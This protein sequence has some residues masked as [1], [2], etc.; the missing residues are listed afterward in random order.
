MLLLYRC[1]LSIYYLLIKFASLWNPKAKLWVNGRRHWEER[2]LN[3]VGK[4][5]SSV[6]FHFA[7]LGE[8]EQG[9]PVMEALKKAEPAT[10]IIISFFSPSGYEI[11]KNYP[12][13]KAVC[14]L[15]LDSPR[16]AQKFIELIKPT[17]AVFTKYEYWFYFFR[18]LHRQHIPLYIVSGIFRKNQVFFKWYG[19]FYRQMLGLITYFF[20][21]NEE[22]KSLLNSLGIT[23][24]EVSG[25]TRFDRVAE[26]AKNKKELKDIEAFCG[27]SKVMVAGSTWPTDEELLNTIIKSYTDWKFIIAPHEIAET[28]IQGLEKQLLGK[29]IR[30]SKLKAHK[31]ALPQVLIIDNIG[32][33]SSL[34]AYGTIAYIGGGFGKGIHN[35]LEAAAF[36]LPVIFGPKYQIFQEAKDLIELKAGFSISNQAELNNCFKLLQADTH[37]E[38][39]KQAKAYVDSHTGATAQILKKILT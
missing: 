15:P 21:Q 24:V 17:Y 1:S 33:L 37:K 12:L 26:N 38:A 3:K 22:S 18:T 25:D 8:F 19:D 6:W 9:R 13:A 28:N 29:T 39:G 10:N 5:E 35:T 4:I 16:N 14:Y 30:Y 31:S 7:S 36:G 34:Y 27:S 32:L 23:Q 11:R 2:L 20:V